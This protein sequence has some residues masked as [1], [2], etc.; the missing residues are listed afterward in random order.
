MLNHDLTPTAMTVRETGSGKRGSDGG[1]TDGVERVAS[2]SRTQ[3]TG[4][5]A[6]D[7]T[8]ERQRLVRQEEAATRDSHSQRRY[9]KNVRPTNSLRRTDLN[10]TATHVNGSTSARSLNN[11]ASARASGNS[12]SHS[13]QHKISSV[14]SVGLTLGLTVRQLRWRLLGYYHSLAQL[15]QLSSVLVTLCLGYMITV[16]Q[17]IKSKE[18]F[19]AAFSQCLYCVTISVNSQLILIR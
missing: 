7:T 17:F 2:R 12:D 15:S 18:R 8:S 4:P 14:H 16:S 5:T 1:S 13:R 6:G 19:Y 9:G 11:S 3:S 10:S